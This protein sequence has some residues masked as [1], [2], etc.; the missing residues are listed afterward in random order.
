MAY[1]KYTDHSLKKGKLGVANSHK[2]WGYEPP[3]EAPDS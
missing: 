1:N 3:V 2:F